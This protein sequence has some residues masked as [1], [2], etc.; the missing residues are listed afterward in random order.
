MISEHKG[1]EWKLATIDATAENQISDI[2]RQRDEAIKIATEHAEAKIKRIGEGLPAKRLEYEER[3]RDVAELK[4]GMEERIL[5][6][7]A[8]L[9]VVNGTE[10]ALEQQGGFELCGDV[11][12]VQAR[13]RQP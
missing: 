8:S 3:L 5:G 12:D 2:L 13:Q 6:L 11:R 7:K 9:E 1:L 4:K 10:D